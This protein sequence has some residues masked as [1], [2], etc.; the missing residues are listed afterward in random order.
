MYEQLFLASLALTVAI[1]TA[2]LF[3]LLKTLRMNA[4]SRGR[5][6]LFAGTLASAATLPYLWFILPR[7][8]DSS[9]YVWEGEIVITLAETVILSRTLKLPPDKALIASIACNLSSFVF[10]PAIISSLF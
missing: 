4:A 6:I 9:M 1:E 5:D 3:I 8:M 7:F 10:G 2:V